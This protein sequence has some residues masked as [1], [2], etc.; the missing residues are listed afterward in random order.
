VVGLITDEDF[1]GA[2]GVLMLVALHYLTL[3][4]RAVGRGYTTGWSAD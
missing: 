4:F 2:S 1:H 3:D